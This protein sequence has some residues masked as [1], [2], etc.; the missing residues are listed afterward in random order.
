MLNYFKRAG[1]RMVGQVVRTRVA[2][3]HF[4][5]AGADGEGS[6]HACV[7]PM[8]SSRVGCGVPSSDP[9]R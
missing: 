8:L 1:L 9:V 5:M 6:V 3:L 7:G 2:V 4:A